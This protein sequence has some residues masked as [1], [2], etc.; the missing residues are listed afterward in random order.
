M[1]SIMITVFWVVTPYH[2]VEIYCFRNTCCPF[3]PVARMYLKSHT[4]LYEFFT[5]SSMPHHCAEGQVVQNTKE[6]HHFVEACWAVGWGWLKSG[7]S[8]IS[9]WVLNQQEGTSD[10]APEVLLADL[11]GWMWSAYW[12]NLGCWNISEDNGP[13][14][15]MSK[16][17]RTEV[18]LTSA[19][20]TTGW[21]SWLSG[22]HSWFAFGKSQ[23]TDIRC[24][25][26]WASECILWYILYI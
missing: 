16:T 19:I 14:T 3:L 24:A 10:H 9:A 20:N 17:L 1:S 23:V 6:T 4:V 26:Y 21:T 12:R 22:Q 15:A 8:D 7:D 5:F 11:S 25:P 18:H 2:L 13:L